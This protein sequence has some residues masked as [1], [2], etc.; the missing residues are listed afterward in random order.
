MRVSGVA[1]GAELGR[2]RY[3]GVGEGCEVGRERDSTECERQR[4][5]P[6]RHSTDR[7]QWAGG[8]GRRFKPPTHFFKNF[9]NFLIS[10]SHLWSFPVATGHFIL[11]VSLLSSFYFIQFSFLGK[12]S[13]LFVEPYK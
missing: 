12:S 8:E 5:T 3:S 7:I 9:G 13:L 4:A 11:L 1:E 2:E 10:R 6:V